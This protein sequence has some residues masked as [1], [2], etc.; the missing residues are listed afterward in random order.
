MPCL[1][2]VDLP[3][4]ELATAHQMF[5]QLQQVDATPEGCDPA[6]PKA[7]LVSRRYGCFGPRQVRSEKGK[8]LIEA[9]RFHPEERMVAS[10]LL[11]TTIELLRTYLEADLE[12]TGVDNKIKV[13]G[14]E[15][16]IESH[17]YTSHEKCQLPSRPFAWHQDDFGAVDFNTYTLLYYLYKGKAFLGG[18]FSCAFRPS[19]VELVTTK[20]SGVTQSDNT[21][22]E[23]G[24]KFQVYN[25]NTQSHRVILMRGDLWHIPAPF[26]DACHGCRD[27]VVVQLARK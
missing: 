10:R 14:K 17:R 3:D 27:S 2:V 4:T 23:G 21:I 13:N 19:E 11:D 9:C 24:E 25:I 8:T 15:P 5:Q 16:L 12:K 7:D 20:D 26:Q 22:T 6:L 1:V 18:N